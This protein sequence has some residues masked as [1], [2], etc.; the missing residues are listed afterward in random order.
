MRHAIATF[1]LLGALSASAQTPP[2]SPVELLSFDRPEAW[3]LKYF[4]AATTFTPL[5]PPRTRDLG[6][7]ELGVELFWIPRLSDSERRVG[8]DGTTLEDLNKTHL[9]ARPRL[10]VGLPAGFSAEVGWVPPIER[11]GG[12]ANLL[13]VALERPVFE[14]GAFSAGLRAW[15]QVGHAEG[16]ITCSEGVASQPP[17]SPGNPL[18]CDGPSHD[19]A[20]LDA[21]GGALTAGARLPGGSLHFGGGATYNDGQFR[22]GAVEQGVPDSTLEITHGWTGWV[23]GGGSVSLGRVVS[24]AAEAFYSPLLVVRPPRTDSQN[25]GLFSVRAMLRLR[26]R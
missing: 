10:L 1:V 9:A 11:H 24:L 2:A 4:I 23:A 13:D 3:A 12:K 18:A 19:V 20:T 6:A 8:F 21:W 25:D 26:L 22:V 17:L 7:L 14:I 15:G 5:A 16:D